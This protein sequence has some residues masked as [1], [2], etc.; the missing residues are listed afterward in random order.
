[1]SQARSAEAVARSDGE[2]RTE[3]HPEGAKGASRS[4]IQEALGRLGDYQGPERFVL[5]ERDE[6]GEAKRRCGMTGAARMAQQA[7]LRKSWSWC[8]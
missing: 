8:A 6:N 4:Q 5:A 3:D 7:E 1:M 2:H